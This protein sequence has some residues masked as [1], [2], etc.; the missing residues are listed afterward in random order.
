MQN[1]PQSASFSF[2]PMTPVTYLD[3]SAEVYANQLAVVDGDLRFTYRQ[4]RDR[5]LRLAFLLQSKGVASGDR[6][7]VLAPNNHV[8]LESHYGVPFAGAVLVALNTRLA[9]AEMIHIVAHA[10]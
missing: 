1:D 5:S 10:G 8:M 3:R 7:A 2:E 4:F 6:V 9:V